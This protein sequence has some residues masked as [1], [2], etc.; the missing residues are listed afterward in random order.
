L[1]S[2]A[3][4]S[5]ENGARNT[6]VGNRTGVEITAGSFNTLLGYESGK[7]LTIGEKNIFL[8]YNT[9]AQ[10]FN[11]TNSIVI[12]NDITGKGSNTTLI[13]NSDTTHTYLEGIISGSSVNTSFVTATAVTSSVVDSTFITATAVTSSVVDA[14]SV[15]ATTIGATTVSV[16]DLTFSTRFHENYNNIGDSSGTTN[17]D[18][19]T[20]NNFRI[21][22]TNNITITISNAPTG[23]RS[24]GFTLVLEDSLPG[25]TVNWPA[26]IEWANGTAP[27]LTNG[28]KDILVFY[29]YDGGSTYYGFLSAANVS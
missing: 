2:G 9:S 16:T 4:I 8:G 13:G 10:G 1:G 6:A 23:P 15:D 24:I 26:T 14:T 19:T 22:R 5:I 12:G 3:L 11:N 29:T 7:V 27:T 28:G 17:I 18:L 20:A 21:N 25:A